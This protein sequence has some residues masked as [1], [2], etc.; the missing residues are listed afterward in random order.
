MKRL[1][2]IPRIYK[3]VT[4]DCH[5]DLNGKQTHPMYTSTGY[6][7]REYEVYDTN[8]ILGEIRDSVPDYDP[9]SLR[10]NFYS[11]YYKPY[12]LWT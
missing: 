1:Y 12:S 3:N 2:P 10:H 9:D 4:S 6:F 8:N 11:I 7:Q 5:F